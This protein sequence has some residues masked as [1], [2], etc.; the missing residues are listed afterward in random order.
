VPYNPNSITVGGVGGGEETV[1]EWIRSD[2]EMSW[3]VRIELGKLGGMRASQLGRKQDV[4]AQLEAV[5]AFS[6][7]GAENGPNRGTGDLV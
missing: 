3:L 4:G 5:W 6:G 1:Y 7:D 2:T